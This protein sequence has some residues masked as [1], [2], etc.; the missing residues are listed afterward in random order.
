MHRTLPLLALLALA[1]P[2]GPPAQE[3]EKPFTERVEVR[4]RSVLV[5]IT[6]TKGKPL[7]KP[8]ATQDLRVLEDGRPAEVVA[9]ELAR[10]MDAEA[11][12]PAASASAPAPASPRAAPSRLPQ[13]LYVDTT[14]LQVRSVPRIAKAVEK[15]LDA[16]LANGPLEIV[17]ADPEPQVMLASTSNEP[18][19]RNALEKLPSVAVG[20]SRIYD[21]RKDSVDQMLQ[22]QYNPSGH[23]GSSAYRAQTRS[24]VRQE[25]LL[26]Q[27]SLRR[28]DAWSATL[29]YDRAAIVY[30][31]NDGFD[32]DLTEV[33]RNILTESLQQED[34]Q[35]AMQ[36]Q[37]EF[38]REAANFTAKAAGVLAGRGATAVVL[39]FGGS[40]VDF[41][42]SA[43]NLHKMSSSAIRRPLNSSVTS[44]FARPFE[45]LLAVA[46]KTGGQVVSAENKF[47]RALDEV[48]GAYLVSFRSHVPADGEPHPLEITSAVA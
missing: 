19:I 47:P 44:Y 14:S 4:V 39:A 30:L 3:K 41:A 35:Q 40:E 43:A 12:T 29:P 20:K 7:A 16:M 10:R 33:Y 38:G 45:P 36:L 28:L 5:F 13:Y 48:G 26:V 23:V 31:C 17:V 21:A 46:D 24:F 22:S 25:M 1:P 32:S 8:P 18:A 6:D 42:N 11:G 2:A 37:Q 27:D 34:I 9:V 15:N